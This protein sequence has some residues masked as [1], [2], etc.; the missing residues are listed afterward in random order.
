MNPKSWML[1]FMQIVGIVFSRDNHMILATE[2]VSASSFDGIP[3]H[4]F[5]A[6]KF[7]VVSKQQLRPSRPPPPSPRTRPTIQPRK[8][9]S[10]PPPIS[11]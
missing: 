2:G 10:P 5:P 11:T 3:S 6:Y 8:E 1:I 4:D 7:N 9:Y